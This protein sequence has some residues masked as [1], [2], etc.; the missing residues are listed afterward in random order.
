MTAVNVMVLYQPLLQDEE[1]ED[2]FD[3][4]GSDDE[5]GSSPCDDGVFT[6][7]LAG[8]EGSRGTEAATGGR[9]PREEIQE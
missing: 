5:V 9:V 3:L 2:E 1:E 8:G 7:S 6:S 4:F